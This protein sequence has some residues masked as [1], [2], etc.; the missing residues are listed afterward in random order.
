MGGSWARDS[1]AEI[2]TENWEEW[3]VRG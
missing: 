2:E 3:V 1:G